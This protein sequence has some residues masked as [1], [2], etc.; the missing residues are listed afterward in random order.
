M[1]EKQML[2]VQIEEISSRNQELFNQLQEKIEEFERQR[3]DTQQLTKQFES[4][5][6]YRN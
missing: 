4:S 5:L 6:I 1:S 2:Q 3:K